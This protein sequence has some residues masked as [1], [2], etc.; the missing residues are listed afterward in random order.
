M[1]DFYGVLSTTSFRVKNHSEWLDDPDV[2]RIRDH[3]IG[4][5]GFFDM[6][7]HGYW[8]FGW[9]DAYP[10]TVITWWDDSEDADDTEE[11]LDM[12]DVIERHI[13]PGDVCQIGVSG[14]EK[15][16]YIGGVLAWVTGKGTAFFD[17]ETGWML[18]LTLADLRAR[19]VKFTED[20]GRIAS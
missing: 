15:L 6:D 2:Q 5:G 14:N 11:E 17:G 9:A 4:L 19:S 7:E 12:T 13:W 18:R 1:A 8:A 10:G 16:R 3:A 20:V